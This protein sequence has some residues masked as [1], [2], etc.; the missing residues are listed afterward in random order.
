MAN[1]ATEAAS[2]AQL[3][4]PE[5][6]H[7]LCMY[8]LSTAA[9][10]LQA[11]AS[12]EQRL[13]VPADLSTLF[14]CVSMS[15]RYRSHAKHGGVPLG[16][17]D[18]EFSYLLSMVTQFCDRLPTGVPRGALLLNMHHSQHSGSPPRAPL[19]VGEDPRK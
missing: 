16:S 2:Q 3:A 18:W 14:H 11:A 10:R 17:F 12:Q 5:G 13:P 8:V 1:E 6:V 9:A 7:E 19:A 4:T 15:L